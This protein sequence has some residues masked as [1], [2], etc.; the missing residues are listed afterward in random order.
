MKG[1]GWAAGSIVLASC[2]QWLMKWG[3]IQ[4]PQMLW[5]GTE[6]QALL[7]SPV[8]ALLAV[9]VGILFYVLS[10]LFWFLTL[11]YLPLNKAYPLLSL[12]YAVVYVGAILLPW[13]H[14][15]F[16]LVRTLGVAVIMVGV[17]IINRPRQPSS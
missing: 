10:M 3:M 8:V 7:S 9:G 16:S 4:L 12:S 6:F 14:E 2:A 17:W 15:P 1:Y 13:F 5:F 11:R